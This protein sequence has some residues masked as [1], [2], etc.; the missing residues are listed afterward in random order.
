MVASSW[1]LLEGAVDFSTSLTH[2]EESFSLL[3]GVYCFGS[4]QL[5]SINN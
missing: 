5:H 1:S 4:L 2:F 3:I